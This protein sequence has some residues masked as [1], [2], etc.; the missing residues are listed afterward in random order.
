[1]KHTTSCLKRKQ[2][3]IGMEQI[4]ITGNILMTIDW[5]CWIKTWLIFTLNVVVVVVYF[6]SFPFILHF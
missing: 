1:M 3:A 2:K 6:T 4:F 5:N